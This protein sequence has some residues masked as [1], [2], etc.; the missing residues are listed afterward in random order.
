[1][2]DAPSLELFHATNDPASAAV[3]SFVTAAQLESQVRFRN[4]FYEE[5][6][7]DLAAHGGSRT[8]AVWDGAVLH[9]GQEA[10]LAV[11]ARLR[12]V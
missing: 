2:A 9:E 8:P 3:R 4:V 10:A 12:G 5:V 6:A 7:R 1:M 11:L